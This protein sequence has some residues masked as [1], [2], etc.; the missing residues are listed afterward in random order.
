MNEIIIGL[1]FLTAAVG[2]LF[3]LV[4]LAGKS[5]GFKWSF[6][7]I[8]SGLSVAL[9]SRAGEYLSWWHVE[10][11]SYGYTLGI[12]FNVSIFA[13]IYSVLKHK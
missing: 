3:F 6:F 10:P 13:A 4:F 8:L 2:C 11:V 12:V 5:N 1:L 7:F 9:V